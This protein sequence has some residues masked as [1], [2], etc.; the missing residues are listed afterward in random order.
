MQA[1]DTG[2]LLFTLYAVSS[3]VITNEPIESGGRYSIAVWP[4]ITIDVAQY[5]SWF[6]LGIDIG[7]HES[8]KLKFGYVFPA[9]CIV[10][11]HFLPLREHGDSH[12]H[13]VESNHSCEVFCK[14]DIVTFE[15]LYGK[16]DT[17]SIGDLILVRI[18]RRHFYPAKVVMVRTREPCLTDFPLDM[19]AKLD[20]YSCDNR[21]R[22]Y[23]YD[24]L[25]EGGPEKTYVT[26]GGRS[27]TPLHSFY[28][29]G[30]HLK[31][32]GN[33]HDY[34]FLTEQMTDFVGNALLAIYEWT[35]I[36]LFRPSESD[37]A[38]SFEKAT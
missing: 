2:G 25:V 32:I 4:H 18:T 14:H 19:G 22:N 8:R 10:L 9:A 7:R 29:E 26:P 33:T 11:L 35:G 20:F 30:I 36:N 16:Y 34:F 27:L 1:A 6:L 31:K 17:V 28:V 13:V 5:F 38:D 3:F 21:I 23:F 15:G 37:E 24:F 12:L